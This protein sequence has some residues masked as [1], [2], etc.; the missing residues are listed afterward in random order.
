MSAQHFEPVSFSSNDS[1]VH[2]VVKFKG[3]RTANGQ[4][5]DMNLHHW[6]QFRDGKIAYY[7]GAE[8]TSQAE[9]IFRDEVPAC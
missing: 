2:T 1:E 9:A 4:T 6:F 5:V 8:D 3:T 7:R